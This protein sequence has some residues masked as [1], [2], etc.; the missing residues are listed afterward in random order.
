MAVNSAAEM[1][2]RIRIAGFCNLSYLEG[3]SFCSCAEDTFGLP[4][5]KIKIQNTFYSYNSLE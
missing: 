1:L 5:I 2:E 4:K 3:I